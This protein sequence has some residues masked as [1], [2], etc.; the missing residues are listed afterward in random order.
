MLLIIFAV[1][2][3][4]MLVSLSGMWLGGEFATVMKWI[5]GYADA[6]VAAAVVGFVPVVMMTLHFCAASVFIKAAAFCGVCAPMTGWLVTRSLVLAA[7]FCM[8]AHTAVDG[9]VSIPL[10]PVRRHAV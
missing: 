9:W 3:V 10:G 8:P 2:D 7:A 5:P 6:R 4:G 1:F